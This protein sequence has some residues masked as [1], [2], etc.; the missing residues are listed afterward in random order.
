M[1]CEVCDFEI[2]GPRLILGSH[3]LCDDLNELPIHKAK[4]YPQELILCQNCLTAHQT[5]QVKKE[6]LFPRSYHYR[7]SLTLDVIKGMENIV[8]K[9]SANTSLFYNEAIK[10]LDIG[11][12]DGSLLNIFRSKFEDAILIGVDPTDAIKKAENLNLSI[13]SFFDEKVAE[14]IFSKFGKVD[15]IT[16]TNVFAHIE[17]LK[18]LCSNVKKLMHDN[19]IVIIENHYLGAVLESNQFD[20]FYHEHPRTYSATSFK[21]IAK[22]LEGTVKNIEFPGR[23][24]GNIRVTISKKSDK[25]EIDFPEEKKLIQNFIKLQEIYNTW[26]KDGQEFIKKHFSGKKIVGKSLPGRAVMLISSLQLNSDVM[27]VI[28]EKPDSPKVNLYVPNTSIQIKSDNEIDYA[29]VE[30]I[31]IWGWH[32]APEILIYLKNLGFQ[33]KVFVPLPTFKQLE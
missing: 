15:I 28:Y 6:D 26:V 7:S 3:P 31:L 2:N 16:F 14:E 12:N 5:Y 33:G 17:N 30:S 13:Q 22:L 10:I 29:E 19:T 21:Y 8:E 23:Y 20:T 27:P 1:I 24:G 11:C 18:A 9:I 32:I 25:Y 4:T